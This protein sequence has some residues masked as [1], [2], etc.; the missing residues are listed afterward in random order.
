VALRLA[1]ALGPVRVEELLN[2]L[3]TVRDGAF[4]I[5]KDAGGVYSETTVAP[6]PAAQRRSA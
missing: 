3:D 5:V 4:L 1:E 6:H 2:F